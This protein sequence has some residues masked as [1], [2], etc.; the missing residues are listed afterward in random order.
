LAMSM[1]SWEL[2]YRLGAAPRVVVRASYSK[3]RQLILTW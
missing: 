1:P 2:A 3:E